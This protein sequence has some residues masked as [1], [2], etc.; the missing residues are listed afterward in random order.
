MRPLRR[1]DRPSVPLRPAFRRSAARAA[2]T[3]LSLW[4]LT[5]CGEK[6]PGASATAGDLAGAA[7]GWNVLLIS[8]DTLRADRLGAYGYK[9]HPNSPE[10]DRQIASGVAF[11]SAMSQRASTWPS[12]ASL[13]TGLYPSAHG[14]TEN[15]YGF[16]DGLPTLP[17]LLRGAG[18]QTGAFLSNMCQAN[19]QAWDSFACS[20]GQD[21][22]SVR[23]ALEWAGKTD[24]KKPYLL[25]VH[26]FG[27]HPPYYV[28]GDYANQ[29]DPGYTGPLAPKKWALEQVMTKPLP[30]DE[31]DVRHLDA[32]YDAAVMGS[33]RAVANL[34]AGLKAAGKLEKTLVI[35]TADHGEELYDHN[36]YLF[37]A[38]SVYQTTLHV[39]LAISAP[40]LL[41]PGGRVPQTVELIDVLPTVLDLLG[42]KRP[43][44]QNGRSLLRYLARPGA[45]AEAKP[46][47]SQYGTTRIHTAIDGR[48]K[49]IDNPDDF[50]PVCIP[51]APPNHYPI[52]KVQ[53]YDLQTDPAEMTDLAA[54]RPEEV[55]RL[56]DLL[57]RRFST[58][59]NRATGQTLDKA[60]QEELKSLGYVAH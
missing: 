3:V 55:A 39:P 32:L 48:W 26:L 35:F 16:P 21:G 43:A 30:L 52:P 9:T 6:R 24:G 15:G 25:W 18:Y 51:D 40:G 60:L 49:L 14:V 34:L 10:I 38:C 46:A 59:T 36:R 8:V 4:T 56:R 41:A 42:V 57:K 20:G 37:H 19:H 5:A 44:E 28:G 50:Q 58:V 31:R 1:P 23:R 27:P 47:F 7:R 54:A 53:L 12:L 17:K 45:E 33:D 29:L 22:K 11:E 13:L 2:L